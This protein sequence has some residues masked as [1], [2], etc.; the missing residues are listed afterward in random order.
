MIAQL[1]RPVRAV[2]GTTAAVLLA[3]APLSALAQERPEPLKPR[4]RKMADPAAAS[5]P[6]PGT[7]ALRSAG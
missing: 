7:A 6:W 2:A 4:S 3:L 1:S 5:S